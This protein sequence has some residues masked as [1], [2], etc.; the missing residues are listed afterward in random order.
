MPPDNNDKYY[1]LHVH[2]TAGSIR[3][4]ILKIPD[5][6]EKAVQYGLDAVCVTEHGSMCTM[7]A[8]ANECM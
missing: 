5:Y 8:E 3:D 7:Y 6:I 4:S 1:S 2:T